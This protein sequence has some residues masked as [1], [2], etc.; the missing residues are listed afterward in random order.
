ML[1]YMINISPSVSTT[2]ENVIRVPFLCLISVTAYF[3]DRIMVLTELQRAQELER[4]CRDTVH[5]YINLSSK[6]LGKFDISIE[7]NLGPR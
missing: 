1:A 4:P 7:N 2:V 6:Y 5:L 3:R